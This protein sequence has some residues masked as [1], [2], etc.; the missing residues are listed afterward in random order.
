MKIKSRYHLC[1]RCGRK[2]AESKLNGCTCGKSW[3]C[4]EGCI[5]TENKVWKKWNLYDNH[6]RNIKVI[7]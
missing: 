4:K 6:G 3:W 5:F 2:R 1:F 7:T